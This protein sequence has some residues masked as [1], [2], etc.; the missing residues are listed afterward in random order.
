MV[1]PKPSWLI[2][3]VVF[4][5]ACGSSGSVPLDTT[6]QD[7]KADMSAP[8]PLGVVINEISCKGDDWV[9]LY[10][11]SDVAVDVS[12]WFVSDNQ[13]GQGNDMTGLPS[14]TRLEPGS[15]LVLYRGGALLFGISCGDETITLTDHEGV[16][17]HAMS[18]PTLYDSQSFGLIQGSAGPTQH[19]SRASRKPPSAA[20]V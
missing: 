1:L 19:T 13:P 11:N 12:G 15:F 8:A 7:T 16:E 6:G 4:I 17:R 14:G 5:S 10:N 2:A 9:E 20:P 18:P 3:M